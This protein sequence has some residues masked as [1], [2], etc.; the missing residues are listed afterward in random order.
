MSL[1]A[2]HIFFIA[3]S[4]LV[5]FGFGVWGVYTFLS[6]QSAGYLVLGILSLASG[7]GLVFYAVRFLQKLKDI[8]YL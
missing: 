1:K 2:F 8:S 5:A 6:E 7:I 3:V 4:T